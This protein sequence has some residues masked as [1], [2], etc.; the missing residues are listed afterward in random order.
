MEA[1]QV[2][3]TK[4]KAKKKAKLKKKPTKLGTFDFGNVKSVTEQYPY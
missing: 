1:K 2:G 3:P 4:Q